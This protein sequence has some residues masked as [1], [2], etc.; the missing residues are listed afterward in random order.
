[1]L[2][3]II[4]SISLLIADYLFSLSIIGSISIN[5]SILFDSSIIIITSYYC[6]IMHLESSILVTYN[7]PHISLSPYHN[8]FSAFVTMSSIALQ[9]LLATR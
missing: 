7:P 6:S 9:T 8:K 2:N 5:S 3:I 4:I 1:M